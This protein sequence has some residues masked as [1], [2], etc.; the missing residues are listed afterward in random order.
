MNDVDEAICAAGALHSVAT[1]YPATTCKFCQTV[2]A[3]RR[4]Q[5]WLLS[6]A[7]WLAA[8]CLLTQATAHAQNYVIETEPNN[9]PAE[10]QPID[11]AVNLYGSMV[12]DD[13]DGFLWTVS[14]NDARKRWDFE[15][16][17]IPGALT[18]VE[19]VRIEAT[20][21]GTEVAGLDRMMKM[22][23][24]DGVT[25]SIHRGQYFEPGEYLIGVA[26]AGG[27]SKGGG[28]FRPPSAS[29]SFG[30]TGVPEDANEGETANSSV[31]ATET[32][33]VPQAS[34]AWQFIISE[35]KPFQI[36]RNPGARETR[37]KAQA[38][39][40]GRE[41]ATFETEKNTWYS[42]TFDE[43]KATQRWDVEVRSPL[44]RK[45]KAR[46]VDSE[47]Q[48]L[49]QANTDN[50]GRIL[51]P[52]LAPDPVTWYLELV[53]PEPGFI[54]AVTI[55][56][57]GQRITGEEAEPNNQQVLANRVNFDQPV[58]GRI[59][60][61]DAADLFRFSLD[62]TTADQVLAFH[63]ESNP[64][65]RMQ[66]CIYDADWITLQCRDGITPLE[67]TDLAL[68]AGDWGV[69]L[70]RADETTYT[71]AMRPQGPLEPGKETEPN[72]I[73]SHASAVPQNLRIKGSFTGND[74]D[75][76]RFQTADVPQLW[77]FQVI[78]DN[79]HDVSYINGAGE[80]LI[81]VRAE[82]GQR[83]V[84]LD[85][86]FLLPGTHTLRLIPK[87]ADKG[88]EYTI[89][90]RAIGPPDPNG[91]LESNDSANRQRL[92]IGQTRTGLITDKADI[93]NYR[94]F[95]ANDDHIRLTLKPPADGHLWLDLSWYSALVGNGRPAT[96][97]EALTIEGIFPAG[98]YQIAINAVKPSDAEYQL[99]LERLPRFS[100][101]SDCEPNG[102]GEG[103]MAAPLPANLLLEG[104]SGDW[105]DWDYY[106]LPEF[107]APAELLV[108]TPEAVTELSLGQYFNDRK[109]LTFD[110]ELP[111]YRVSVPA[112]Q[113][114]RF[115][116]NSGR[117][118]YRLQLAFP[119]GELRPVVDDLP[120]EISLQLAAE[121][122]SAFRL[123]GQRIPG[124]LILVNTGTE[125]LHTTLEAAT[126]DHRW[127]VMLEDTKVTLPAGERLVVPVV[128]H[129]PSDVWESRPV[130]IS[131][132][133]QDADGRQVEN[134]QEIATDSNVPLVNAELYWPIPEELRGGFNIAWEP[135]GALWPKDI[136]QLIR[137]E[138]L[139]DNLVFDGKNS[140]IRGSESCWNSGN[141]PQ[142]TLDLPGDKPLPVAGIAVNFFGLDGPYRAI[143]RAT[144]L[145]SLD[146]TT[147][148]EVMTFDALPVLT[149]QSFA[150]G[151]T[152]E[153]R[154]VQLRIDANWAEQS[155]CYGVQ[156]SEWKVILEPGYD[157]SNG[158]GF[159]IARPDL[160]GHVVWEHPSSA[161]PEDIL[162]E[163]G[164]VRSINA[165]TDGSKDF[166]I[167]FNRNRVARITRV[168]WLNR[169]GM[170]EADLKFKQLRVFASLES[171]VGPWIPLG[172]VA[173]GELDPVELDL[174][175]L[176]VE[177]G[178][179]G[180]V[181]N[182]SE[183]VWARFIRLSAQSEK[184]SDYRHQPDVVRIWEAPTSMDYR[185]VLTEWGD[186]NFRAFY[187]LQKGLP[188]VAAVLASDNDSRER[189]A[190]LVA[191]EPVRG[192]VSLNQ[193]LENWY[194]I[195]VTGNHNT[196]SVNLG[197]SPTVRTM[198]EL[199]DAQGGAIPLRR[200][201]KG[202]NW[203][204]HQYEAVVEPGS[205]V[206]LHVF[207]P[208]RNVVFAWDTSPSVAGY[209]PRIRNALVA[210]SSHVVP[211][212]EAVNLMP[213]PRGPLLREWLGEPY[214]L[215]TVL[216]EYDRGTGSSDGLTTLRLAATE[217]APR[218]GTKA[219]M[220]ITDGEVFRNANAWKE[221]RIARPR[222]FSVQVAG[223]VGSALDTMRDWASIN[224]GHFSQLRYEGEM[225][226]SFDRATALMR[227]PAEYTLIANSDFRE[228]PG[229]GLLTVVREMGQPG[230]WNEGGAAIELILDASGSM[231]Q[232]VDGKR[233]ITMA[234]EVLIDAVRSHIPAGTPV[235]LRVFGHKEVDSC[236]TDL[237]IPLGPLDPEKAA[238]VIEG[239]QA[240]NLARTPI[241]D[242]LAAVVGDL[243]DR[244][245][246]TIVLVTDG[247]ETCDG[248]PGSVID[249]LRAKGFDVNLNIV[250]FAINDPELAAQFESW[251]EL[252]GGQYYAADDQDGLNAA[253][254]E[255]LK[256]PFKVLDATGAEVAKGQVGGEPVE[257][258]AGYYR[259]V[260]ATDP[261]RIFEKVE[262]L[263]ES[264]VRLKIK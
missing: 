94:F 51:F 208:P 189:A 157:L 115:M 95:L 114:Q 245:S 54:Q 249:S 169:A 252:G 179:T 201:D 262:V 109:R 30:E 1:V 67:L 251:A 233:R 55:T 229:P 150:I 222:I 49:L 164:K 78:G 238:A 234:R 25:P 38:I 257:L 143:Q 16:H 174:N 20:K 131:V 82:L 119:N 209:I 217:L 240:M 61:A 156:L 218:A 91:E 198:L 163:D 242:S 183:P 77:R 85:N 178:R 264:E 171:S 58:T 76:Y 31:T 50:H 74:V 185:S 112:G 176:G 121:R 255:A 70:E 2:I 237:E 44:G 97:G 22:G 100:C 205:E 172:E 221:M 98:D 34:S 123:V 184:S 147:F 203:E 144:L 126:S 260:V 59:N 239:I 68:P 194:R 41:F 206:W 86:V 110:P 88:G 47:G 145:A 75:F 120:L 193:K 33:L 28:V 116:L 56:A 138:Y 243:G 72:D 167:G 191:N 6:S 180:A 4:C 256:V 113:A 37:E 219:V 241:A 24:R 26:S 125:A 188:E 146:G 230:A 199:E 84:R 228:V 168:E 83:R 161:G 27:P 196:L 12:G 96:A 142:I 220:V 170:L 102:M 32:K 166:V 236:R 8:I 253:L 18:I 106:Q 211:G 212:R 13:Q 159:N 19:I 247:E 202:Q 133:A 254:V 35:G 248:D 80:E 210:F 21:D 104:Y 57:S 99:S 64:P 197:G 250:G 69:G 232:R 122:V 36:S 52:D 128:V 160:G 7:Q 108:Q 207:E 216:N 79:L 48:E 136:S 40:P 244:K 190:V 148:T 71:L 89:L 23:T 187:E 65:A 105:G 29:L 181:L 62:D 155:N 165:D 73:R 135:F 139:R 258:E 14:D 151:H 93:D 130:R 11:G 192:L 246:G 162:L 46:L 39:I 214:M 227:R 141:R 10:A 204:Q 63:V 225:E 103:A 107:D 149:G 92:A 235:A 200:V 66:I 117:K 137:P 134:W 53:T 81:M 158:E 259:V 263:G 154:K 173:L 60:R 175:K 132:R 90:A 15:L 3:A 42:F 261:P 213:F 45:L 215:Q 152:V 111:G 186:T 223:E 140:I 87:N 129:A 182:L 9:T 124:E 118:N 224:A 153:A 43:K 231:L 127:Q 17:G 101:P 177:P 5:R 195:L 226:V